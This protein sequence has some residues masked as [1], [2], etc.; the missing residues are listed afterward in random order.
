M[1][2][3]Y[4]PKAEPERPLDP[5]ELPG[6]NGDVVFPAYVGDGTVEVFA[7]IEEDLI[8]R[9]QTEVR[10]QGVDVAELLND[11]QWVRL[12]DQFANDY[13]NICKF[14]RVDYWEE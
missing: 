14:D 10:Y 5:P 3:L 7:T 2:D 13:D 9:E 8:V 12:Q 1:F 6:F 4:F 11:E